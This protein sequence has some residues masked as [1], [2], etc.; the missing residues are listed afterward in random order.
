M[1]PNSFARTQNAIFAA[2]E[3]IRSVSVITSDV[4]LSVFDLL[5]KRTGKIVLSGV[6]KSGFIAMKIAATLTSLGHI[7]VFIHP[8]EALHGDLGGIDE[9]DCIIALSASGNTKELVQ[10]VMHAK[11]AFGVS[12]ISIVGNMDSTLAHI[13]DQILPIAISDEGCAIGLA[14]MASTTAMLVVG[15][16]LSAGLTSPLEFTKH[17]FARLHPSGTLGLSLT[18]VR[19]CMTQNELMV[20]GRSTPLQEVLRRMGE[21]GKGIVGVVSDD[22]AL[23]GVITD[24]DIRRL[25]MRRESIAGVVAQDAMNEDP[26]YIQEEDTLKDALSLMERYKIMNL[27][28]VSTGESPVGI[29]HMHDILNRHE[30]GH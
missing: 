4:W 23:A 22:G 25:F 15:D 2:E 18:P 10:F 7:A 1:E 27:F 6:G 16:A 14:P 9:G 21:V 24:G 11:K 29:I 30:T 20:V 17:D 12:V 13:A 19:D 5:S 8:V 28:I 3:G 26:K